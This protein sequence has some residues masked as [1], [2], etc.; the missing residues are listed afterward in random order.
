MTSKTVAYSQVVMSSLMLPQNAN[1]EGNV[2]GGEI[3]KLMDNA[4]G[5]VALKHARS[6]VVTARVD[7]LLFLN[8]CRIGNV[9]TCYAKL[10]FVGRSSMEISVTVMVEDVTVDKPAKTAITS[11]FT[12]VALDQNGKPQEVPSLELVNE[13]EKRLF[14]EG[15]QRYLAYKEKRKQNKEVMEC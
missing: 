4:A 10:T 1:P 8:P 3:M 13:E 11:Y 15:K 5:V 7:E 14:K 12:I 6:N 2:H 9:V